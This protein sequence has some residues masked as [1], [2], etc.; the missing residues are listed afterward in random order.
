MTPEEARLH[1]RY[2]TWASRKLLD[3]VR[4]LPPEDLARGV[5]ISHGSLVGTLAHIHFA[6]RIWYNRTVD[7]SEPFRMDADLATLET[8][9][10]AILQKWEA[11]AESL[12]EP[13]LQ[14]VA[15]YANT[16]GE[17]FRTPVW[18]ILLHVVNHATLH[19]GQAVGMIRQLG[20]K[21]P[22]TDLMLYYRELAA[23]ANAT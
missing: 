3:A 13:G 21:P 8:H 18:Q 10:P 20:I 15:E 1:L 2:S 5:G 6:D 12:D 9:W 19:R 4:Q 23:A 7:S 16:T 14:R 11:W 22:A 17:T